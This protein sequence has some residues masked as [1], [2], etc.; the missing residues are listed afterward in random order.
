MAESRPSKL[1]IRA[2]VDREMQKPDSGKKEFILPVNP[3]Q[4]SRSF[5]I[6]SDNKPS[7]GAQGAAGRY[8]HTA[9]EQLKLDFTLDGTGTI[10][11]Y[12]KSQQGKD[13]PKQVKDF[14]D[15]VYFMSGKIH[16]PR[17]LKILGLGVEF[18]CQLSSLQI[19]Y[20][21]FK[22]DGTP[23]RAKVSA[24]FTAYSEPKRRVREQDKNSPDLTHIRTVGEGDTLPLMGYDIY[25]ETH[26]YLEVAKVNQ[27]NNF[28]KLEVGR[29][30]FFPPIAKTENE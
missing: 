17:L 6:K 16:R 1:V 13:V 8:Q 10:Y 12:H 28:R 5:A 20:T 18:Y 15:V 29:E 26:R 25:E 4:I 9:P 14:Q 27:L 19:T 7:A 3:E 11:G 23:L 21:L 24:T 2:F 22:Q 30:L